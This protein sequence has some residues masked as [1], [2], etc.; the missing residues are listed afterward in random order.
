MTGITMQGGLNKLVQRI[1]NAWKISAKGH[2]VYDMGQV[3]F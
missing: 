2:L 3:Q 1:L